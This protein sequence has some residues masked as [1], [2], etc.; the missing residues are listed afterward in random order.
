LDLLPHQARRLN[1]L[2]GACRRVRKHFLRFREDAYLAARA[3]GGSLMP[4]AFSYVENARELT[5]LRKFIPWLAEADA[6]GLQQALRD[7][8]RAFTK[9]FVGEAGYRLPRQAEL[10]E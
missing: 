7:L 3:A 8:D 1:A 10:V 9:F 2:A 4:G 6:V 5:R